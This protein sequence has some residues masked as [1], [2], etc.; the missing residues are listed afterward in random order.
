MKSLIPTIDPKKEE[1]RITTFL[2][3]TLRK[4]GFE[5]L[6]IGLS[7]GIDSATSL[8]LVRK[9]LPAK[10]IFIAHLY[11]FKP[12]TTV[13]K[14]V[15][16]NLQIPSQNQYIL[17]I[18]KPVDELTRI[19]ETN[20][21]LQDGRMRVGNIMARVRMIMLFDLAKKHNALVCGTENKTEH[22]LGY[23][24]R[25][26]DAASDI[27][28]ITHLYKTRIYQLARYLKIPQE[29]ISAKPS[30]GLWSGQTDEGEFGFSYHE[31]DQVLCLYFE[32]K[33][34][35]E[36]IEKLGHEN[37]RKIINFALQNSFKHDTP[38]TL[39]SP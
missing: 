4:T 21:Q 9:A 28:P 38:Y 24:T 36:K 16:S 10:N 14:Q 3:K 29:I 20:N 31:A 1:K 19:L 25:F 39:T 11:Y 26:G 23:F 7:G 22:L 8:Y 6:I 2:E 37:A 34:S 12:Q 5:K 33:Q 30:A 13:I 32:K 18:K 27:E 17:S 35:A 15:C